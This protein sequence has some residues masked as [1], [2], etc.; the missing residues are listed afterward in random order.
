MEETQGKGSAITKNILDSFVV[1]CPCRR[2]SCRSHPKLEQQQP[3]QRASSSQPEQKSTQMRQLHVA[4]RKL[5]LRIVGLSQQGTPGSRQKQYVPG[6]KNPMADAEVG[7]DGRWKGGTRG[8]VRRCKELCSCCMQRVLITSG[9]AGRKAR[10]STE[11]CGGVFAHQTSNR[12][13]IWETRAPQLFVTLSS[14]NDR[15]LFM[16]V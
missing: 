9:F 11:R 15:V 4:S 12:S 6:Q 16:F 5:S 13:N 3:Q 2:L 8:T 14:V 10:N 7:M 1:P